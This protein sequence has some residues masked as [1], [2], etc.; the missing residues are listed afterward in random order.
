[1]DWLKALSELP[2][3]VKI[4]LSLV[5]ALLAT[6]LVWLKVKRGYF[7]L[8]QARTKRLYEL[9]LRQDAF[10]VTSGALT[11]AVKD[12]LNVELEGDKIRFAFQHDNPL[13]VLRAF[14]TTLGTV[15]MSPDGKTCVDA[16]S[17]PW[18]SLKRKKRIYIG[19][20]FAIYLLLVVTD[21]V[22]IFYF[23]NIHSPLLG[24]VSIFNFATLPVLVWQILKIE[25]ARKLV[26]PQPGELRRP[27][28]TLEVVSEPSTD[29]RAPQDP[30][31][32]AVAPS[33]IVAIEPEEGFEEEGDTSNR[34][35]DAIESAMD[36][37]KADSDA[38]LDP[39]LD[40]K[41]A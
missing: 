4:L 24:Y 9:M 6:W 29:G 22:V 17:K 25:M 34:P 41:D 5:S 19:F 21:G 13:F 33:E 18:F 12:A 32:P 2:L 30:P 3:E 31:S 23:K 10:V 27:A 15:K 28:A 37:L 40:P 11:M 36:A 7:S 8:S 35:V 14:K 16:R 20:A 1:M 39:K 26:N 38:P